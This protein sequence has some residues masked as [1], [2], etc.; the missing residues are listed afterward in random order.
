MNTPM[1]LPKIE[2]L[3]GKSSKTCGGE[4]LRRLSLIWDFL[5]SHQQNIRDVLG[6]VDHQRP[7]VLFFRMGK[8]HLTVRSPAH[9]DPRYFW[10]P[11]MNEGYVDCVTA[12]NARW[13]LV[14]CKLGEPRSHLL[15]LPEYPGTARRR[16]AVCHIVKG[17]VECTRVDSKSSGICATDKGSQ[18]QLTFVVYC[19]E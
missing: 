1:M 5:F 14:L 15:L 3:L 7:F 2:A 18:V 17:T 4:M 13:F 9:E 11:I 10:N 8:T 6:R 19:Y 12:R 16:H